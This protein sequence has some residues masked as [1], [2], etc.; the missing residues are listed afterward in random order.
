MD[1]S[2]WAAGGAFLS[3]PRRVVRLLENMYGFLRKVGRD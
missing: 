2:G 3:L 1:P